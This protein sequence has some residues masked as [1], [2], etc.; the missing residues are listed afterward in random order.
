MSGGKAGKDKV[1]IGVLCMDTN[2][3][4]IPGHIRNTATF[5]FPVVQKVIRGATAQRLVVEADERLLEP[6]ITAA[7]ELEAEGV[8]AITGACG[9][10][11][12]FQK[13]L[14]DAVNVPLFASSLIQLPMVHRM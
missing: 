9:F 5:D 13:Q 2:F 4:K 12:L 10:L 3:D 7:R 14:A 8:A 1:S 6:F 11:V